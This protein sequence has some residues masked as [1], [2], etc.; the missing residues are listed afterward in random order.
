MP[1]DFAC[2]RGPHLAPLA[3]I[4]ITALVCLDALVHLDLGVGDET[5]PTLTALTHCSLAV[6]AV[7]RS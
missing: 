4:M 5:L 6:G 3:A 1:L 7:K 2:S